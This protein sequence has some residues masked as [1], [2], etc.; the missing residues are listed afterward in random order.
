MVQPF[1]VSFHPWGFNV[2]YQGSAIH[3]K[4]ITESPQLGARIYTSIYLLLLDALP[5]FPL[6][7]APQY[8]SL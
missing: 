1:F 2:L 5:H 8:T 6:K 7:E 4:D 3:D